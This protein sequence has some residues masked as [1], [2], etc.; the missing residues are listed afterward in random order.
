MSIRSPLAV[1]RGLGSAKSGVEHWWVQRVTAV[2]LVP[3]TLWFVAS[4]VAHVGADYA[5]VMAWLSSPF[6]AALLILYLVALFYHSQLGLQ[7]VVEDYVHTPLLKIATT[8]VLQFAN[9]LLAVAAIVSV[10]MIVLGADG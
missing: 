5:S 8:I 2:A 3:L 6:Q 7:V 4:L 10:I 9:I 1:A